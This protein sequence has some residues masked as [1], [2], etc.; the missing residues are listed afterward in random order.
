ML[1][2]TYTAA[3]FGADGYE[4]S[5]ECLVKR[6]LPGFEIV[7]LPDA[8]I[9]ESERRIFAGSENS[10]LPL[11]PSEISI[12][13]APADLKKEGTA[14]DLAILAAVYQGCGFLRGDLGDMCFLGEISFSGE[15]RP[16]RGVLGMTMAAI[17]AGRHHIFVPA[18]NLREAS[19]AYREGVYIYGVPDITSLLGHLNGRK[20][21]E[22]AFCNPYEQPAA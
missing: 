8:A 4:V 21:L 11:P 19:V 20:P 3:T 16:V 1:S 13:L 14:M 15:I 22:P 5:V 6:G 2:V 7:G 18:G 9:R 10:G 17:N 12:N